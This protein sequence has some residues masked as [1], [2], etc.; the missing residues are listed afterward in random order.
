VLTVPFLCW[1]QAHLRYFSV[2]AGSG[3]HPVYYLVGTG[4]ISPG[5]K[6]P[7]R[8]VDHTHASSAEVKSEW[9]Y[10]PPFHCRMHGV[11]LNKHKG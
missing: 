8:E 7:V 9:S 1:V 5:M 10:V 3:A 6:R 11:V 2:Q 4:V